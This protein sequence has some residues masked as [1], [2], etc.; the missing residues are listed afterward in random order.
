[1]KSISKTPSSYFDRCVLSTKILSP[2][3]QQDIKSQNMRSKLLSLHLIRT[4]LDNNI[5]VFTSPLVTIRSSST[6]EPASFVQ[7]IAVSLPEPEP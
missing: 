1:M 7:A 6:N 3:Q 5:I 2:E 4:L